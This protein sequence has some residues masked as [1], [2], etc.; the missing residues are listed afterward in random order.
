MCVV[1]GRDINAGD[2]GGQDDG[3]QR[4][5]AVGAEVGETAASRGAPPGGGVIELPFG[6]CQTGSR[7]KTAAAAPRVT[8][9][10]PL[11]CAVSIYFRSYRS[12][13][14]GN[15]LALWTRDACV[16]IDC[17]VGTLRD[18]RAILRAHTAA[19]GPVAAALVTHAHGDHLNRL[20]AR[21]LVEEGI[22]IRAPREVAAHLRAR[23]ALRDGR[24]CPV[25]PL[26]TE[27]ERIADFRVRAIRLSHQPEVPTFGFVI[28]AGNGTAQR[29]IVV[30]TDF[31][32][33]RDVLPHLADADFVF[34]EANHDAE[35][36]RS[37]F[38]PNSRYHLPNAKAADLLVEAFSRRRAAPQRVVLGHLSA[39]RNRDQLALDEVHRGF[40]RRGTSLPFLLD[41]APKHAPSAV[42][43]LS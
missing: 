8:I 2:E 13:S 10:P 42:I 36:L 33:P 22:E 32:D 23:I 26:G 40:G 19:H 18:S 11:P 38:N 7:S 34:V 15:C 43:R 6:G 39:E 21:A 9:R 3:L 17:G 1:A 31:N 29:R 16:L 37:H 24:P 14:A 12:S 27:A 28:E 25:R 35:L 4:L 30:A 41:T 5:E 20:A